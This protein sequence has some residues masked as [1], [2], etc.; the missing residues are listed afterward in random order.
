MDDLVDKLLGEFRPHLRDKL[1]ENFPSA[2]IELGPLEKEA[3][4]K[5]AGWVIEKLDEVDKLRT[6]S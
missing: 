6:I 2:Q 3:W 4:E 1:L 5:R